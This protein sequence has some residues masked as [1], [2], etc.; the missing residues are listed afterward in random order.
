MSVKGDQTGISFPKKPD[1]EKIIYVNDHL[2][3]LLKKSYLD[4]S[5]RLINLGMFL[6]GS[7]VLKSRRM[8]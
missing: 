1:P 5:G 4:E 2:Y 6:D 3:N 7:R 8:K